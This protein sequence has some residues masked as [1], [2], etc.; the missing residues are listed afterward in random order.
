[1]NREEKQIARIIFRNKILSSDKQA[2]EDLFT[3][4]MQATDPNFQPVKPQGK[5]GDKKCDGFNKVTGQY[6]QVYAPEDLER[7][8]KTALDKLTE[9]IKGIF[10]YWQSISPIKEFYFV[11]KDNNKGAYPSIH[12]QLADIEKT[13]NIKADTFLSNHLEDVFLSLNE[14]KALS[15]IGGFLPNPLNISNVD[16][17]SLCE[18]IDHLLHFES[19]FKDERF[20]ENPDF[21]KK[22]RFNNLSDEYAMLLKVAYRQTYIIDDYFTFQSSFLKQDLKQVFADFYTQA[23]VAIP[24]NI[25]CRS[26]IVFQK[27]LEN[28]SPKNTK[29]FN[30]AV[31]VLMSHYFESCDIFEEPIEPIQQNLFE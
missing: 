16:I 10:N 23:L 3:E 21:E 17:S 12:S 8:E 2:Y 26:D 13:Y 1:M 31:L 25:E 14:E 18:V 6:Y 15:I 27:I 28:A 22:I 9:T 4:V 30:D 5:E 19:D 29:P 24:E 7:K 20:P 11:I